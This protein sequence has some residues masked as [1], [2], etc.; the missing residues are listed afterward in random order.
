MSFV[1]HMRIIKE[2][3]SG[4]GSNNKAYAFG[5][6]AY[7]VGKYVEGKT[8]Y[9]TQFVN[10][11]AYGDAAEYLLKNTEK[12]FFKVTADNIHAG[13]PFKTKDQKTAVNLNMTFNAV[14]PPEYN[15][16]GQSGSNQGGQSGQTKSQN[17]TQPKQ[18]KQTP[19]P[20]DNDPFADNSGF[21]DSQDPFASGGDDPF[22]PGADGFN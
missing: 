5:T 10:F 3:Q 9:E 21:D 12:K 16:S 15:F 2:V 6:A 19:P 11:R 17:K 14:Q 18:S 4:V 22:A 13:E 20:V 8:V 1:K 7:D